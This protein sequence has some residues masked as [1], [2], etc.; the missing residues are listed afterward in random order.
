[1]K[2]KEIVLSV[3]PE[4]FAICHFDK[5]TSVPSWALEGEFFSITKTEDELS[6]VFPQDQVPGGVLADKDWRVF[7][8]EDV[9]NYLHVAGIISFLSQPL[10]DQE[11]SI[12]NVSTFQTNYILVKQENLDKAK[13]ILNKICKIR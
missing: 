11:I 8:L 3:L 5:N 12:F 10:A 1:M 4:K 9:G 7:K 13:S 2:N 6:V